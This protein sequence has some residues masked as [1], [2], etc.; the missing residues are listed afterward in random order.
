[1]VSSSKQAG[2][3]RKTLS[4]WKADRKMKA[5]HKEDILNTRWK[6]AGDYCLLYFKCVLVIY[7]NEWFLKNL[8]AFSL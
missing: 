5:T 1:M 8:K 6:D 7:V 3:S 4:F 2:D